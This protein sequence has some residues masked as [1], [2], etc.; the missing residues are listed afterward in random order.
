V[1]DEIILVDT[2][3]TDRTV[4]I[5]RRY[6]AKVSF[7][8]WTKDFSEARNVALGLATSDWILVLDADEV[9]DPSSAILLKRILQIGGKPG[10]VRMYFLREISYYNADGQTEQAAEHKN[11]RLF[12]NLPAIRYRG[13]IHEQV[14][15]EGDLPAERLTTPLIIHHY[16]YMSTELD[17]KDRNER[18]LELLR[19]AI[20][21]NPD[22]PFHKYNMGCQLY[23]AGRHPEALKY[24]DEVIE[25]IPPGSSS[26]YLPMSYVLAAVCLDQMKKPAEAVGR[27]RKILE[28]V[29]SLAD[30]HYHLGR[31]LT[32]LGAIEEAERHLHLA[33]SAQTEFSDYLGNFDISTTTWK[34]LVALGILKTRQGKWEEAL[35]YFYK[36][37]THKPDEEGVWAYIG[38]CFLH[39]G[40]FEKAHEYYAKV[41]EMSPGRV[42]FFQEWA[43]SLISLGRNEEAARIIEMYLRA[44]GQGDPA[45]ARVLAKEG[46]DREALKCLDKYIEKNQYN[47]EA[48]MLRGTIFLRSGDHRN[49]LRDLQRSVELNPESAGAH[50]NL[51]AILARMGDHGGAREHYLLAASVGTGRAEAL[52][53]LIEADLAMGGVRKVEE[54]LPFIFERLERCAESDP[55]SPEISGVIEKLQSVMPP[56]EQENLGIL[57]RRL[58]VD[59]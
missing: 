35:D 37:C 9:L 51:G 18:N 26:G 34:P 16:G 59:R 40:R 4:E 7:F 56:G 46:L 3:S 50:N 1:A 52:Y 58:R 31:I 48:W 29:P 33:I 45:I 10:V 38:Q 15:Y 54:D 5:A 13:K 43:K 53:N 30:A 2:G 32:S 17:R 12:P 36:A 57:K 28:S 47:Y 6:G 44:Q 8:E 41:H 19:K 39:L 23:F 49:A 27:L 24:F 21:E 22:E 42:D 20:E 11:L 14:V 55:Q 25:K